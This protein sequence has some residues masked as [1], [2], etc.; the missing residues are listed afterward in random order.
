MPVDRGVLSN[1]YVAARTAESIATTVYLTF[2]S[3]MLTGQVISWIYDKTHWTKADYAMVEG[4]FNNAIELVEKSHVKDNLAKLE[5][6]NKIYLYYGIPKGFL[7]LKSI[8]E[9][10]SFSIFSLSANPSFAG[11]VLIVLNL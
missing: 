8:I 3:A 2:L 1:T 7:S 6:Y 10:A 5:L 4:K 11:F 9:S